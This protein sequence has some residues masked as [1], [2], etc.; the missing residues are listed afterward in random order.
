[1]ISHIPERPI[2]ARTIVPMTPLRAILELKEA[3]PQFNA[4]IITR[5][6]AIQSTAFILFLK[7]TSFHSDILVKI[8]G[9]LSVLLLIFNFVD[10]KKIWEKE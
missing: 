3:K 4:P 1:M 8:L 7:E 6:L 2:S 10:D 9:F 5:I